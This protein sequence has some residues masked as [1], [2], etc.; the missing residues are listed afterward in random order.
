MISAC[1][2]HPGFKYKKNELREVGYVE[3]FDSIK[4]LQIYEVT[5]ALTHGSYSGFCDTSKIPKED[6]NFMRNVDK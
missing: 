5:K 2:N 3:F 6:F 4:R 1:V